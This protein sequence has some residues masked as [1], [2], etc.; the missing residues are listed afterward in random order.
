MRKSTIDLKDG[1]VLGSYVEDR[2]GT[3]AITRVRVYRL[4][5][6]PFGPP[7]TPDD[8]DPET[9]WQVD[10][11]DTRQHPYRVTESVWNF[12]SHAQ[13]I[14]SVADFAADYVVVPERYDVPAESMRLIDAARSLIED[15]T[16]V[17]YLRALVDLIHDFEPWPGVEGGDPK[18]SL[19]ESELYLI[20]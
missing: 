2:L 12:T 11:I 7:S 1:D 5:D 19:I 9:P 13:A 16:G 3:P 14:A 17:E 8:D 20:L 15:G 4:E 18:R 6:A 10:G